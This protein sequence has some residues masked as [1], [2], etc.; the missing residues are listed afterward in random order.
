MARSA[1][2]LTS[3]RNA[4]VTSFACVEAS[5]RSSFRN[6]PLALPESLMMIVSPFFIPNS[7]VLL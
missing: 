1:K 2:S 6:A 4:A 7:L 3:V 5:F